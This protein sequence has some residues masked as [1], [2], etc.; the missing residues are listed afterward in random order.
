[1]RG[2]GIR[3]VG[4]WVRDNKDIIIAEQF[5]AEQRKSVYADMQ[6]IGLSA[7]QI[8]APRVD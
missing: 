1:M 8:L 2:V 5:H 4:V 7:R 3:C 6:N